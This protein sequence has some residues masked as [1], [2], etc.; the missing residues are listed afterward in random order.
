MSQ[1]ITALFIPLARP[2]LAL[3]FGEKWIPW[4]LPS[5]STS[6]ADAWAVVEKFNHLVIEGLK[7]E[8]GIDIWLPKNRVDGFA[9][10]LSLAICRAA[11]KTVVLPDDLNTGGQEDS[12]DDSVELEG[13]ITFC[14]G[15][16]REFP[17]DYEFYYTHDSVSL[18][19]DCLDECVQE[20][21]ENME[22]LLEASEGVE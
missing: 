1:L 10:K 3:I 22:Y 4:N 17:G 2:T 15:C 16:G 18:C 9:N 19:D 11:L 21:I 14:E 8:W 20:A 7:G 12:K 13:E 6:I 5:Y